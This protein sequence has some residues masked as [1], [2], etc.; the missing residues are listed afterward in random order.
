MVYLRSTIFANVQSVSII[1]IDIFILPHLNY[2]I[3][4]FTHPYAHIPHHY[5]SSCAYF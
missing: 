5:N 3:T 4:S 1:T 2:H